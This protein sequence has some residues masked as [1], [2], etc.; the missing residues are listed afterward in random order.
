M[1]DILI[2]SAEDQATLEAEY[3]RNS[4]PDKLARLEIAKKVAL[5]EKEVQVGISS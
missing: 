1:S 3:K 4:K 2:N 5:G